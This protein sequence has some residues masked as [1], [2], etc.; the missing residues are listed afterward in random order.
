MFTR[1]QLDAASD[2]VRKSVLPTPTL[3]WPQL[4]RALGAETW[5]KHENHTPIGAFKV[6]GGI[7]FIDELVKSGAPPGG[8][9]TA[10]RGNH[11]QSIP[12]AARAFDI[13]VHVLVP[14][15][16]STEKNAA[17]AGWGAH[18]ETFGKDFDEARLEAERRAESGGFAYVTSF[19]E[20]LVRGVATYA[21]EMF[22]TIR[23][24]DTVYVPIGMGSGIC[25]V[26][27]VRDLLGLKTEVVGVV[28]GN[29]DAVAQSFEAG[30]IIETPTA[31]TFAD[32][33]ACRVPSPDAM[34]II[35]RGAARVVRVSD[36]EVAAA[37]RLIYATTHNVAE[38]AGAAACAAAAKEKTKG[39]KIAVV[40]TGGNIDQDWFAA[41]LAGQTPAITP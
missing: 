5:V 11:G 15:G 27:L 39:R 34:E 9:I 8:L 12:F 3:D 18:V 4:S 23:D 29:A 13:P 35:N 37:I 10:T 20:H 41:I 2:L 17:M 19:G 6:R 14:E 30:R 32:G 33:M 38:G 21:L 28:S 7:V 40:L 22:E 26:I 24:L 31:N 25:G 16:N 36:D 1:Q